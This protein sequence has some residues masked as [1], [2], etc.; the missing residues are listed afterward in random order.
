M[1]TKLIFRLASR[2]IDPSYNFETNGT[3]YVPFGY[4]T[5]NNMLISVHQTYNKNF[6]DKLHGL[7][8]KF[9]IMHNDDQD[10]INTQKCKGYIL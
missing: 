6:N 2:K 9:I 4:Y 3:P 7:D 8:N 10:T 5:V 1:K